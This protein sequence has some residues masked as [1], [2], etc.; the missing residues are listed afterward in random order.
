MGYLVR[1]FHH[2]WLGAARAAQPTFPPESRHRFRFH[3]KPYCLGVMSTTAIPSVQRGIVFLMAEWS[4]PAKLAY[5]QL[6]TSLEQRGIPSE[7]LHVLDV[8]RYPELYQMP[9]FSGRI[10]GYGEAAVVR[11]GRIVFVTVLG[12]D[13][14]RTSERCEELLRVYDAS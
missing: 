5:R 13:R 1:G 3:R 2:L 7:Q 9:E 11:D 6:V 8:D 12:K 14:S 4:G 10:H